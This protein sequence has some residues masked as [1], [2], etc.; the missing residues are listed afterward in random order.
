MSSTTLSPARV[1]GRT[2]RA[3]W[4]RLWTVK[5]TWWFTVVAMVAAVLALVLFRGAPTRGLEPGSL[6]RTSGHDGPATR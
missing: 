2:C 1:L 3:E 6:L 5:G 4:T